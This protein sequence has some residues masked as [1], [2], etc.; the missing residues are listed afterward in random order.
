MAAQVGRNRLLARVGDWWHDRLGGYYGGSR[1]A[2]RDSCA[3]A[4][5]AN[6]IEVQALF[7]AI[8]IIARRL[9]FEPVQHP[10][11]SRLANSG[12]LFFFIQFPSCCPAKPRAR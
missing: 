7:M 10:R 1:P 12:A 5:S 9:S 4:F 11:E 2:R 8:M 3:T 6:P